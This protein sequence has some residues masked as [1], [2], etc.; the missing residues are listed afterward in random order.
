[1][2]RTRQF[3]CLVPVV[4]PPGGGYV[5][6]GGTQVFVEEGDFVFLEMLLLL[7][8]EGGAVVGYRSIWLLTIVISKVLALPV[9]AYIDNFASLFWL[10]DARLP[11]DLWDFL[12]IALHKDKFFAGVRPLFPGM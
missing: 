4:A 2:W 5:N 9:G 1:M 10:R 3:R 7:F 11:A 8:G 6:V 12:R